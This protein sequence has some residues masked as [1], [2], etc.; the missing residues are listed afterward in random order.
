VCF[1]HWVL[2]LLL[3]DLPLGFAVSSGCGFD[4]NRKNTA[5]PAFLPSYRRARSSLSSAPEPFSYTVARY[6]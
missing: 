1:T 3:S 2:Q 6:L 5:T 4:P